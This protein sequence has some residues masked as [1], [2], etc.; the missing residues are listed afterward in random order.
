MTNKY[1]LEIM[2][3]YDE[4]KENQKNAL[5]LRKSE[6]KKCV[7][8]IDDIENH[9]GNLCIKVSL[10]A[11][12]DAPNREQHLKELRENITNLRVKKTELLVS[13]GYPLDYLDIKYNCN[14]CKDTGFIGLQKCS[15]YKQK[16]N[17][18]YYR[19]SD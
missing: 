2:K 8:E 7:P 17:S 5:E 19:N 12:Q 13:N 16:L 6:V 9:I 10:A 14:R 4:I 18:I 3:L 15:C 1:H 11:F